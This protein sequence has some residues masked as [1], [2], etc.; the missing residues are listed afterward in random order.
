MTSLE[1]PIVE[2]A[3]PIEVFDRGRPRRFTPKPHGR[4]T[5]AASPLHESTEHL[6]RIR[7][8]QHGWLRRFRLRTCGRLGMHASHLLIKVYQTSNSKTNK[9]QHQMLDSQL[10][11]QELSSCIALPYYF[12][13]SSNR[14]RARR[15]APRRRSVL[16]DFASSHT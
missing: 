1:V 14:L 11:L 2:R 7:M 3:R 9:I 12:I 15:K 4:E 8:R 5:H 13:T 10:F 6:D 16:A